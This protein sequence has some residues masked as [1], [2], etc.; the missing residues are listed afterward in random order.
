MQV[1]EFD[2]EDDLLSCQP[3]YLCHGALGPRIPVSSM[4][5]GLLAHVLGWPRVL[6]SLLAVEVVADPWEGDQE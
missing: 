5:V 4:A 6:A 3:H 2:F 1:T